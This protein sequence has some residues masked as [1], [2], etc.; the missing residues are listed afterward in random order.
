MPETKPMPKSFPWLYFFMNAGQSFGLALAMTYLQFFLTDTA[1]ITPVTIALIL[2]VSRVVDFIFS[3][4]AGPIVQKSNGK[5][6]QFRSWI[7]PC[8]I[9]VQL[10]VWMMFANPNIAMSAKVIIVG[11]GYILQNAPMNFLVTANNGLMAK[12]A[13]PSMDNRMAVAAKTIQGMNFANIIVAMATLPLINMIIENTGM[14]GFFIVAVVYGLIQIST[15]LVTVAKTKEYDQ[16]DPNFKAI[17]GPSV[18]QIY[19]Q[20]LQNPMVWVLLVINI[21]S[22]TSMFGVAPLGM[23]YFQYSVKNIG[24][25]PVSM[26]IMSLVSLGAAFIMA[27]VAKKV[28]KKNSAILSGFIVACGQMGIAMFAHENVWFYI[29]MLALNGLGAAIV[30][31]IGVNFWL[32]AAEYQLY[33]TGI[34][35]RPTAMSM[36]NVPMKIGMV[37]AGPITAAVMTASGYN[38]VLDEAGKLV[39]TSMDNPQMFVRLLGFIPATFS[40]INALIYLFFY[41]ITDA[42]AQEYATENQKRMNEKMAAAAA[43]APQE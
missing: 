34:D 21:L 22:M 1:G 18:G 3:I 42:K 4:I 19:S 2:T 39:S 30:G 26:T 14:N 27:P 15:T 17:G 5:M 16:Y 8:V 12:V 25:Q 20:L 28:G 32:D 10:G 6:G 33:K 23:Y 29:A 43:A 9:L 35:T 13:G 41:K 24:M 36:A 11:V 7:L 31:V 38:Q 37:L 40:I